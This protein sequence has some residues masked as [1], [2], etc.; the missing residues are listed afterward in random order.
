MEK[1]FV[2]DKNLDEILISEYEK[3]NKSKEDTSSLNIPN[4]K[5]YSSL[6]LSE[7]PESEITIDNYF[8]NN[9]TDKVDIIVLTGNPLVEKYDKD[10]KELNL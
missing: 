10:F 3:N 6:S 7:T 8:F 2:I 9:E 1:M 5:S 4:I